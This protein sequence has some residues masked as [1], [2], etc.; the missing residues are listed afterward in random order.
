MAFG[1]T[2]DVED[3]ARKLGLKWR[4]YMFATIYR[5]VSFCNA[6]LAYLTMALDLIFSI[7]VLIYPIATYYL[8]AAQE[9][10]DN[11]IYYASG[12]LSISTPK[13]FTTTAAVI[14]ADAYIL[15]V[16]V[17]FFIALMLP[18]LCRRFHFL[19]I[20]PWHVAMHYLLSATF[21]YCIYDISCMWDGG[22]SIGYASVIYLFLY[23]FWIVFF[24]FL[25][26]IEGNSLIRPNVMYSEWFTGITVGY[27]LFVLF[28]CVIGFH[29]ERV[30][31]FPYRVTIYAVETV[32]CLGCAA[33]I[34]FQ[35]P[36]MHFL[37]NDLMSTKVLL[38]A[39][40]GIFSIF[41]NVWTV[42]MKPWGLST[43]P[44]L[45][46][47]I[48]V[49]VHQFSERRRRANEKLLDQL[50]SSS[51]LSLSAI[52]YTLESVN[53]ETQLKNLIKT[54]MV[55]GNQTVITNTFVR[56]C[57][58]HYPK[59]KWMIA[60]IVF[61][62][63]TVWGCDPISYKFLL[64]ILSLES[65]HGTAELLLFQTIY[66]FMQVSEEQSPIITR[67]LERYRINM[68]LLA[69]L[70][71]Q[72]WLAEKSRNEDVLKPMITIASL[73]QEQHRLLKDMHA[74]YPY[75]SSTQY[76]MA[77]YAVDFEHDY[78]KSSEY[79]HMGNSILKNG[80]SYVTGKLF[81]EFALFFPAAKPRQCVIDEEDDKDYLTFL[82]MRDSHDRTRR[83]SQLFGT[84]DAYIKTVTSIFQINKKK[85]PKETMFFKGKI[86]WMW[87]HLAILCLI[88]FAIQI[89][90]SW[91]LVILPDDQS[92]YELVQD[93]VMEVRNFREYLGMTVFDIFLADAIY[94][95]SYVNYTNEVEVYAAENASIDEFVTLAI[96]HLQMVEIYTMEFKYY[97]EEVMNIFK[98]EDINAF[99]NLS[100]DYSFLN[101]FTEFHHA[102]IR[103]IVSRYPDIL[104]FDELR[105]DFIASAQALWNISQ[106][107]YTAVLEYETQYLE[108]TFDRNKALLFGIVAVV[109]VVVVTGA[110]A[111]DYQFHD[112]LLSLHAVIQTVQPPALPAIAEQFSKLLMFKDHQLPDYR[113]AKIVMFP[114]TFL[115]IGLLLLAV[116]PLTLACYFRVRSKA[117]VAYTTIPPLPLMSDEM[118]FVYYISAFLE[119]HVYRVSNFTIHYNET[120]AEQIYGP[121]P[122]CIHNLLWEKNFPPL[123][124][125]SFYEGLGV[126]D[127]H[128]IGVICIVASLASFLFF[129]FC[130]V[131]HIM[132]LSDSRR[133]LFSVPN[134]IAQSNPIFS[135]TRDGI[136]VSQEEVVKFSKRVL[137]VPKNFGVFSTLFF[138]QE[139]E[140]LCCRGKVRKFLGI[141]P[142]TLD[143]LQTFLED[144]ASVVE[145]ETLE[146]FF[147]NRSTKT[148]IITINSGK[149]EVSLRFLSSY[150][151][152]IRDESAE[153]RFHMKRRATNVIDETGDEAKIPVDISTMKMALLFIH[154]APKDGEMA[155]HAVKSYSDNVF[156]L[157]GKNGDYC[158]C[159]PSM[160][161]ANRTDSMLDFL[162]AIHDFLPSA[163]FFIDIGDIAVT[164]KGKSMIGK[165]RIT[166]VKYD[167][168][169]IFTM[170][171]EQG[172]A[173]LTKEYATVA[174]I[175]VS[176]L[177]FR[178]V[179]VIDGV[180]A[181]VATLP[182]SR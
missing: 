79:Y 45:A 75:N 96:D 163:T 57:L 12:F 98:F 181:E 94:S 42:Q 53:G 46:F 97:Y 153:M 62:Y 10:I 48:F 16:L 159:T 130:A 104:Y 5:S 118:I 68:L 22:A 67:H 182:L 23:V 49:G 8:S 112:F 77:I 152:F 166:G 74:L 109:V 171:A 141:K 121:L 129:V 132:T 39:V 178:E 71:E 36:Y 19:F 84:K 137:K 131:R 115:V 29:T 173:Y 34:V 26:Y 116:L 76:E 88:Y 30:G 60:Y 50:D 82:S 59:S 14:V 124:N 167:F 133:L 142:A 135:K 107:L 143:E 110:T 40:Y 28:V 149:S 51:D 31:S 83:Y 102:C 169:R 9:D 52:E 6:P 92:H 35:W 105:D 155:L 72:F 78:I 117:I 32:V 61:L 86:T 93:V 66:C 7:F 17:V 119:M 122:M 113:I 145:G 90:H 56:Y 41:V 11:R 87:I 21:G 161:S 125:I 4:L 69:K 38:Y 172:K 20:F 37:A 89:A 160:E 147:T 18:S 146:H 13:F 44:V 91:V 170:S 55:T 25:S 43:V 151:L 3:R 180:V 126:G 140:C 101:Q 162:K 108:N 156:Q 158:F 15:F 65:L 47:I 176:E 85:I 1:V 70:H 81:N 164:S 120:L 168:G 134:T 150:E 175:D 154:R 165:S 73:M 103:F 100:S 33:I 80:I 157:E 128:A 54:G 179:S 58:K 95:E 148:I 64:H 138:N 139:G 24:C 177:T 99:N 127:S 123:V 144:T 111:L 106:Q 27:P 63:A 114:I 2:H 174:G 136:P